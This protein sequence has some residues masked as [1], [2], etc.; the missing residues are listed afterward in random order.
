M[1]NGRYVF[2]QMVELLPK[3]YFERLVKE[4]NNRT[5][6]WGLSYWSQLLVLMFGQLDGCRSLRE[7][8]DATDRPM[9]PNRQTPASLGQGRYIRRRWR[10]GSCRL[11]SFSVISHRLHGLHRFSSA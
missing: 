11:S 2:S 9:L 8:T 7:L 5:K 10:H 6:N 4:C 1:N 3:R